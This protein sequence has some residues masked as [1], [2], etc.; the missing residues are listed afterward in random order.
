MSYENF[1]S[2]R[3][4]CDYPDCGKPCDDCWNDQWLTL[5]LYG[6]HGR[7]TCIRHFCTAHLDTMRKA[8][9]AG[10]YRLPDDTPEGWH[11]WGEGYMYPIYEPCIPVITDVLR[12]AK[13]DSPLPDRLVTECAIALFKTDTNWANN[14]PTEQ[15]VLDLWKGQ[16]PSVREQF[17]K[18]AFV[19]LSKAFELGSRT[20]DALRTCGFR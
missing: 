16:M 15:E 2:H 4:K 14:P 18:R 11:T 3:I 19:V 17:E 13:P 10:S 5:A 1:L 8:V 9:P 7:A 6:E 20:Q 12:E